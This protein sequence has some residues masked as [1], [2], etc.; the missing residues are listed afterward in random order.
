M[1]NER[2]NL[3]IG[4]LDM[5]CKFLEYFPTARSVQPLHG[6]YPMHFLKWLEFCFCSWMANAYT[7]DVS[8]YPSQNAIG[9]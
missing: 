5:Y 2:H 6:A 7:A 1:T 8:Y 4:Y 3:Y 9:E